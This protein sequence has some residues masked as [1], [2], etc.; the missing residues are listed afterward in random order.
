MFSGLFF[1]KQKGTRVFQW[2]EDINVVVISALSSTKQCLSFLKFQ[3]LAKIFRETFVMSLKSTSYFKE[4]WKKPL[5]PEQNKLKEIWDTVLQT[6]DTW[7]NASPNIS[8][9]FLLFKAN[10]FLQIFFPRNIFFRQ[11]LRT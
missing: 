3:F 10:E 7:R 1:R 2:Q 8:C 6:K 11:V 9:T 4:F 5:S